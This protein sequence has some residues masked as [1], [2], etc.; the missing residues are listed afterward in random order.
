[1]T[2]RL[3]IIIYR[4]YFT[5]NK[6]GNDERIESCTAEA[7]TTN[8]RTTHL[9]LMKNG[10]FGEGRVGTAFTVA[11]FN[12]MRFRSGAKGISGFETTASSCSNP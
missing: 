6:G 3:L 10:Q 8:T 5:L 9:M 2:Y 11:S 1:M 4:L 12:F 7:L